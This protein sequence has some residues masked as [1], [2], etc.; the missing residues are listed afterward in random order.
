[1]KNVTLKDVAK[2]ANVSYATVS[3]ALSGSSQIGNDTRERIIKLCDEMGYTAN[4]VARSMVKKKT[5]LLGFVVSSINNQF[6]AE[7]A[8]YAETCARAH[9]YN[10]MLCNSGPDLKQEKA[11][12]KLL[13]GRQVDGILIVPQSSQTFENIQAYAEQVPIVFLSENLRD[14][15]QSY[16]AVDN[17]RG[18][19]MGT[20]YLY[21][22]GHRD[23]L[24]FG[25]RPTVT[26]QLRADGYIRACQKYGLKERFFNN[27]DSPSSV[28]TGYRLAKELFSRPID[29]TA[30][31]ASTDSNAIG[32]MQAADEMGID[33][34]GRISLIGF[35][36]IRSASLPRIDLT[37][38]EQ[39][40]QNMATQAVEMLWDKIE[41]GT[42][43]YVHQILTPNLIQRGTC[44]KID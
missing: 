19:Y 41:N 18:T 27:N 9:G 12:V 4:Y 14:Q 3:R 17:A 22:L 43:G 36:N 29:Y 25:Q 33:I 10:I 28:E 6:M 32:I 5:D 8:F 13:L 7:L 2:A 44:R 11:V 40:K 35:D 31:F 37:T 1:M 42:Q 20:E 26:H 21:N 34:P 15:P 39:P 24:Y 38:V 16:V 30:I 23:I